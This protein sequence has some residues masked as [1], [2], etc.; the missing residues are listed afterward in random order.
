M[1]M[2]DYDQLSGLQG[3]EC[4]ICR[5]SLKEAKRPSVDHDHISGHVRG[6]LCGLCNVGLGFFKDNPNLLR[7]AILYLSNPPAPGMIGVR[8]ACARLM[9]PTKGVRTASAEKINL[10]NKEISLA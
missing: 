3:G 9:S 5:S 6:L 1:T 2:E 4:A 10:V 8:T 7:K